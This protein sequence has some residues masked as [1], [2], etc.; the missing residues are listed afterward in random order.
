MSAA[1]DWASSGVVA[2]TGYVD[3]PPMVPPGRAASIAREAERAFRAMTD[4]RAVPRDW[5]G[6][7][8]E[9]AAVAGTARRAPWSV[10]GTARAV[11]AGDGWVAVNLAR[12][13]DVSAVAAIVE[14]DAEY[15]D[16]ATAWRA[17]DAWAA[18]R[19]VSEVVAR[20]E[21]L[22]V[23]CGE[24]A[25]D[26]ESSRRP[27]VGWTDVLDGSAPPDDARPLVVDLSALWAGP[28]CAHL[29]GT[30][31]AEV[32]KVEV[33]GRL[34]GAR[35]GDAEF[36]RLL[37][38]GHDSVVV[39]V[40]EP[41]DRDLLNRLCDR[42]D[43]VIT[44]CRPRAWASLGLFPYEICRRTPTTWVSITGYGLAAGDRVGFGDDVAMAAGLVVWGDDRRPLPCGDAIAD[45]LAGMHAAVDALG[46]YRIGGGRLL[47][48]SM[49]DVVAATLAGPVLPAAVIE[50]YEGGWA[51]KHRAR[52]IVVEPPRARD[53]SGVVAAPGR[54]TERWRVA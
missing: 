24:I 43:I 7:L 25:D 37:N 6:L 45:P 12:P 40:A 42:A 52:D 36:Y 51:L 27:A 47:D 10:G 4:S 5:H 17:L 53:V 44:A 54:D 3:G 35:L 38:A 34:D 2:L 46:S 33:A 26:A 41:A 50:P 13:S 1:S 22:G 11:A 15:A 23:P 20:T 29:L 14:A 9:R 21:L 8:G 16:D 48:V 32:I 28:L 30:A 18:E 49:R 31:G 19:R 39:D